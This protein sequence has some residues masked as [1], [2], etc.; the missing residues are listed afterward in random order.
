M[1]AS[2]T[3]PDNLSRSCSRS[4]R[5]VSTCGNS[6]GFVLPRLNSVIS[7]PR[8]SADSTRCRPRKRV[9]P[10]IRIFI[11]PLICHCEPS[12]SN[13]YLREDASRLR[14]CASSALD[15]HSLRSARISLLYS[16]ESCFSCFCLT[17]FRIDIVGRDGEMIFIL[18]FNLCA[19]APVRAASR[20]RETAKDG[21]S[22]FRC[23][24]H[25]EHDGSI[26]METIH[27]A[28][29]VLI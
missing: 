10:M 15:L 27:P 21:E 14:H 25:A 26:V 1:T 5:I 9:P 22:V 23:V 29:F 6:V 19:P 12:G 8:A 24:A 20:I 3:R 17:T 7:C 2:H 13:P 28:G 4:P 18:Q 11:T 16:R